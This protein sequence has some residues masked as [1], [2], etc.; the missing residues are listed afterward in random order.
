MPVE[1]RAEGPAVVA[2]GSDAAVAGIPAATVD[3]HTRAPETPRMPTVLAP[4]ASHASVPRASAP[5][6]SSAPAGSSA[7]DAAAGAPTS[8]E[9]PRSGINGDALLNA[10][11]TGQVELF[12]EPILALPDRRAVH[13]QIVPRLRTDAAGPAARFDEYADHLQHH[14]ALQ[15]IDKASVARTVQVLKRLQASARPHTMFVRM[16]DAASYTVRFLGELRQ[17][18]SLNEE[19]VTSLAIEIDLE[20]VDLSNDNVVSALAAVR[21]TG[22]QICLAGRMNV[23]E[24]LQLAATLQAQFLK[25]NPDTLRMLSHRGGPARIKQWMLDARTRGVSGFIFRNWAWSVAASC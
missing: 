6:A 8:P 14:R 13:F 10:A 17:F 19:A 24:A 23:D 5:E 22:A 12:I 4:T 1:H 3:H 16:E 20:H 2:P 25:M 18:L 15:L 11:R 9:Q 21:D 7:A